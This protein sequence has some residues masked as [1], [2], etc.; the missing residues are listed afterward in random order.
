MYLSTSK[1][2]CAA[3]TIALLSA[4][5]FA[6]ANSTDDTWN[7]GSGT[8]ASNDWLN[9]DAGNDVQLSA[10]VTNDNNNNLYAARDNAYYGGK[11]GGAYTD[12]LTS[13]NGISA[14]KDFGFSGLGIEQNKYDFD[15]RERYRPDGSWWKRDCDSGDGSGD[16]QSQCYDYDGDNHGID[17]ADGDELLILEFDEAVALHSFT[18]GY[19]NGDSDMSVFALSPSSTYVAGSGG[20]VAGLNGASLSLGGGNSLASKGFELVGHYKDVA[21]GSAQNVFSSAASAFASNVWAIATL[22]TGL[23][24]NSDH[25][26]DYVKLQSV[27]AKALPPSTPPSEVPAPATFALLLLGAGVLRRSQRVR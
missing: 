18:L 2:R 6:S 19:I 16:Y 11:L 3:I 25:H 24:S 1:L 17:N 8:F 13:T 21:L 14:I 7:F 10:W 20:T 15:A 9:T 26:I 5:P 4:A 12:P 23:D 27:V 22:V